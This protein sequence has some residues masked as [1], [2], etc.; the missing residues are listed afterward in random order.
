MAVE[1]PHLDHRAG[2]ARRQPERGVAH[3]RS[4]FAEDRAEELLLR[5]HRRLALGRDLAA[6][7]VARLDLGADVDDARLVEVAQRFLAD[8]GNVAGDV[9]RPKLGVAGHDLELFD[10]DRGEDVVLNDPLGNQDR[11]LI[12]VAVPGHERDEDVAAER[13]LTELGRG[14][15]RDGVAGLHRVTH[16]HQRTLVDAGVLVGAL[17]LHQRV[18]VDTAIARAK[19]AGDAHDNAGRVHLVDNAGTAGGDG[20]ARVAG[21]R[22]LHAGADERRVG[23]QQR[24]RLALH[25]GAHQR[26]VGVIVLKE[27]DQR[28]RDR[29]Q[30]LGADV[31][32]RDLLAR[33]NQE[34]ARP[35]RGN[36]LLGEAAV[37]IDLGIRLSDGVLGFFHRR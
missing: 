34:V 3:V 4:L 20:S 29:H 14:T 36:D 10:V 25:V 31:H 19:L 23:L 2:D 18:D 30:L 24:H 17:E 5:C 16:L 28:S 13:E 6:Q 21:N 11:V 35:P 26:P 8:V 22:F 27:R 15:V 12:I 37:R 7:D 32:Q 1:H 33:R 9:L